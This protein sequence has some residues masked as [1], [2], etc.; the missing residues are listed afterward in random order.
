M[1]KAEIYNGKFTGVGDG[2]IIKC[3][4]DEGRPS[5]GVGEK[6]IRSLCNWV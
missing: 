3:H 5:N 1:H 6:N 2:G 4:I